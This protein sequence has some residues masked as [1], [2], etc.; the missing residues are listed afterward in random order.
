MEIKKKKNLFNF[1]FEL[2]FKIGKLKSN[3]EVFLLQCQLFKVPLKQITATC[4]LIVYS[5]FVLLI[6]DTLQISEI[7][8]LEK[9]SA[10]GQLDG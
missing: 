5:A 10:K 2:D 8:N 6:F 3:A 9:L 1:Q 4:K 7:E